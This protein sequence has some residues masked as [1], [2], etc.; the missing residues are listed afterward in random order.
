M[1]TPLANATLVPFSVQ[2]AE[3]VMNDEEHK[4][5]GR[6]SMIAD[7]TRL[8]NRIMDLRTSTSQ[9]IFRIQAAIGNLWR[10]A[11]DEQRF[12]EI[13]TPKLQVREALV[14]NISTANHDRVLRLN[15]VPPFSS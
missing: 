8:S 9:S 10:Y 12:V 6:Q 4:V 2:E 15:L 3:L 11:L 7:R 14:I 1:L 5:E 13:H